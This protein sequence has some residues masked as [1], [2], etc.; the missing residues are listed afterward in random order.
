MVFSFYNRVKE[1]KGFCR[2]IKRENRRICCSILDSE[3]RKWM[4]GQ[5]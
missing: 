1:S 4:I 5:D 2:M 3:D